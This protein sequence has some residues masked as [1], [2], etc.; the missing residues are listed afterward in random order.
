M[1]PNYELTKR[2]ADLNKT[3]QDLEHKLEEID[4]VMRTHTHSGNDGSDYMYNNSFQLKPGQQIS[5][6]RIALT[7]ASNVLSNSRMVGGIVLGDDNNPSDGS[8]NAQLVLDFN[9]ENDTTNLTSSC[10][11]I[12]AGSDG[13]ITSGG[14]TLTTNAYRFAENALAGL[15]ISVTDPDT[16]NSEGFLIQSNTEDTITI[17]GGTWGMTLLGNGGYFIQTTV[18]LG[19]SLTP[20]R[21]IYGSEGTSG[22]LRFGLG[23]TDNGQNGLL[24]MDSA[25]DLYWRDKAS[26]STQLNGGGSSGSFTVLGDGSNVT[27]A[28]GVATLTTGFNRIDTEGGAGSDD[29]DNISGTG[30]DDGTLVVLMPVSSARTIVVTEAGNIRLASAGSFTMDHNR[31]TITLI[32][33]GGAWYEIARSDN[34]S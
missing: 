23:T 10:S 32:K 19:F 1:D 25:G 30:I 34:D 18:Y 3:V 9:P 27:I 22:G 8:N 5:T 12:F 6:G 15:I 4:R 20:W 11:P 14:T 17:S 28:S 24:Y 21:R 31:D 7:E 33:D 29:L 16:G 13:S 26:V 2:I